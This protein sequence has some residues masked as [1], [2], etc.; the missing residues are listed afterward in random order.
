M[1]AWRVAGIVHAL[2]GWNVHECGNS[3]FDVDKVWQAAVR[4][5]FQPLAITTA[6]RSN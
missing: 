4:H 5:G 1:S 2:E 6:F 3:I